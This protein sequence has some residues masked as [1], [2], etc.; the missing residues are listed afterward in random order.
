MKTI[1]HL[2][3]DA[4]FVSV[5]R[6]LDPTLEG[7]AVIVGGDPTGGVW[8]P[9]A[10]TKPVSSASIPQCPYVTLTGS[11]PMEST[12][13]GTIRSMYAT[14]TPLKECSKNYSP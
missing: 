11:A 10:A 12:F 3:M 9:H 1:F 7:Q 5:E 14:R 6:I 2:D 4:F 8:L 13:R